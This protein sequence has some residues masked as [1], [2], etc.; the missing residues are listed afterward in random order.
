MTTDRATLL[1]PIMLGDC[2][3]TV[4]NADDACEASR[5]IMARLSEKLAEEETA[6]LRALAQEAPSDER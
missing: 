6:A 1:D 2:P 3:I 5:W 4:R